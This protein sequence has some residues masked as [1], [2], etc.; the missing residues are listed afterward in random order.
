[1]ELGHHFLAALQVEIPE[2]LDHL[3][4]GIAEDGAFLVIPVSSDR[5]HSIVFPIG[6]EDVIGLGKILLVIH[7]DGQGLSGDVPAAD[8]EP[9]PLLQG[10]GLPGTV[11]HRIFQEIRIVGPVHPHIGADENMSASQLGL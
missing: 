5:V 2:T 11:Q 6:R 10:L 9:E 7:Q 4:G 3:A 1:M 8:P